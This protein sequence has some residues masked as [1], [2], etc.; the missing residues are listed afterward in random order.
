MRWDELLAG[1]AGALRRRGRWTPSTRCSSPTRRARPAGRRASVHVHGGFLVK[2]A[3]EVAL[4][5]RPAARTR[6]CS[7]SPTSAGSWDRGRSSGPARSARPCSCSTAP[8]TTRA[9][10]PLGDGRAPPDHDAR[11]LADPDP[12]ADPARATSPSGAHDLSS[13]RILGS[14]GEPWNPEPYRWFF[15]EVGGGRCPI[16]NISGGTEVGACF[17]SPLPI[18]SLKPLHPP[19]PGAGHGRRRL[20]ARRHAGRPGEVGELVCTQPWPAMTRGIWRRPRA[21]PR[22][23]LVAGGRT[24]GSTAT[25]RRSTRTATGSCTDAPTTR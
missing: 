5:G 6:S 24:C 22:D 1:P 9:R 17:L 3:E 21:L 23:L 19:R 18:T 11:R 25:G 14:T 4:P 2:I 20:G 7:G 15:E 10:P 12:R 8:R 16:I 13:L